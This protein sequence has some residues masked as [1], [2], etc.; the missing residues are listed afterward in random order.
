MRWSRGLKISVETLLAHKL[1]AFLS[2]LGITVGIATV[3]AMASVARGSEEKV[4]SGIRK[5]GTNLVTITAGRVMLV[6]GRTR[7]SAAVTTL[8]PEDAD[9][10]SDRLHHLAARVAAV[11]SRRMQVKYGNIGLTTTIVGTTPDF[12][13]IRNLRLLDGSMFDDQDNRALHRVAVVGHTVVKDLFG[14]V[15]P[16]GQTIRIG[17]VPFVVV[18]T[19]SPA[20]V[21]LGGTDQDDQILIPLRT[22]L[23][24]AFNV[25]Y[26]SQIFVQ[27][28]SAGLMDVCVE[29]VRQ[30]LREE[31]RLR[32]KSDDF[33]IQNQ[34]ELI[35]AE[36]ETQSTFSFLT[37]SVASLSLAVGG[38]GILTVM[39][40]SVRERVKEIGLR[41][42]LGA[43]RADIRLQFLLEAVMLSFSGGLLG[44]MLGSAAALVIGLIAGWPAILVPGIFAWALA[45]S[46]AVGLAF[47][48]IPAARASR[49][50]PVESLR[51]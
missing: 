29:Q 43:R 13:A 50:Q 41:R 6:A 3:V 26:L 14:G 19:L 18:G 39:L 33:T 16:V 34:L 12:L 35:R 47:G 49:A 30:L 48:T 27:A 40:M 45:V 15:P 42:A 36:E 8:C 11:Q 22:S 51:G 20:G 9:A 21:D 46:A 37:V 28:R 2:V 32:E 5:M 38:V 24:R 17:K 44:A 25:A 7:Q 23:R 10:V 1:R 31:H 4:M